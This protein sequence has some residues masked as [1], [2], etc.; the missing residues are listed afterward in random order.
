MKNRLAEIDFLFSACCFSAL[1]WEA[2]VNL[3]A[4]GSVLAVFP[5]FGRRLTCL[6]R[7]V[8][9]GRIADGDDGRRIPLF[10][11][12]EKLLA[13]L[14]AEVAHPAGAQPLFGCRQAQMFYGDGHVDVGMVFL[15][16]PP[17]PGRPVV[18]ADQDISRSLAEP[19]LVV[20]LLHACAVVFAG[21]EDEFPWLL[22]DCRG[23][24]TRAF[25][26]IIHFFCR[27][28]VRLVGTHGITCLADF[29]KVPVGGIN[30]S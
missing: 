8:R 2:F 21:E 6:F 19:F 9:C 18:F 11:Q 26:D 15:V 17:C 10:G 28:G 4:L 13:E 23:S 24:Q 30:L 29:F 7:D 16:I 22:V 27:N 20:A 3:Y 14:H 25:F 5:Y 12:F 1:L